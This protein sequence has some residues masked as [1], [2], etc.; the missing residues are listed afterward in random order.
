[1]VIAV[2]FM[3]QN[4]TQTHLISSAMW[5]K[6]IA[7]GSRPESIDCWSFRVCIS[8]MCVTMNES[9]SLKKSCNASCN[10]LHCL[11]WPTNRVSLPLLYRRL[12]SLCFL[13]KSFN[14]YI[15]VWARSHSFLREESSSSQK[16]THLS[17]K[18]V[19]LLS[20]LI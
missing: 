4:T 6:T 19:T 2:F 20:L 7:T 3:H 18:M 14:Y 15:G 16:H 17:S 1:M 13:L 5:S 11:C 12:L 10:T 9:H 8:I